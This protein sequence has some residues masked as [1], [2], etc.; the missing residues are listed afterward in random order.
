VLTL[1]VSNIANAQ[2]TMRPCYGNVL[3]WC[4]Y[5]GGTLCVCPNAAFVVH[6]DG[7]LQALNRCT[8]L[9]SAYVSAGAAS[10]NTIAI[11]Y[12]NGSMDIIRSGRK[13]YV[14][15]ISYGNLLNGS[16]VRD[17]AF[18]DDLIIAAGDFGVSML[19]A[20][21]GNVL[22]CSV[23][24]TPVV[25][26]CVFGGRIYVRLKSSDVRSIDVGTQLF[27]DPEAW[28]VEDVFPM[29]V[30]TSAY[31]GPFPKSLPSD[32][33]NHM[34]SMD[35]GITIASRY[36]CHVEK[37]EIFYLENPDGV[38]FTCVFYN[39]YNPD[40]VFLGDADGT[41]HEYLNHKPKAKYQGRISGRITGMQCTPE[42]DLLI[43][44]QNRNNP[45]TIFDH[46]GNWHSADSFKSMNCAS[47]KQL[48]QISDY[49]FAVAMGDMGI[50]VVDMQGTPLDFSDDTSASTYPNSGTKVGG[51]V[52]CMAMDSDGRL[53]VG[54]NAGVAYFQ[55]PEKITEGQTAC[56]RPVI[57]ETLGSDDTY[58]QYL[59]HSKNVTSIA[60][61]AAGRKWLATGGAGVFLVSADMDAELM[62]LNERNSL[63]PSDTVYSIDIVQRTGLVYMHT[64]NGM[65]SYMGD[66]EMPSDNLENVLVYPNPVRPDYDGDI[67]IS[68]LEDGCDV[69]IAD[70]SGH[71]V[72]KCEA[73]GGRVTWDGNN[74]NGHRCATGVYL[75]M[76]TNVETGHK[77][78]KKLLIVK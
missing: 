37:N 42:G 2:W 67:C 50:F 25:Q 44:S 17:I 5:D 3:D 43:L 24:D 1:T 12:E 65:A 11:G 47:P 16:V 30:E 10:G 69:R 52:N 51:T 46:N 78:V 70:I 74:L 4:E 59:L 36:Y 57:T 23:M 60:V 13:T 8:G 20:A 54:T 77:I 75:I 72:Y 66:V 26:C 61:D 29:G 6:G 38:D 34:A 40:H 7:E 45:V 41:L 9:S 33:A 76:V 35:G 27:Q 48:L 19:D 18:S 49:V 28:R 63:L 21:S 32:Q 22:G 39:P 58:S 53:I 71:L 73:M 31:N 62:R 68:G 14:D 15:N 64:R 55:H 56:A